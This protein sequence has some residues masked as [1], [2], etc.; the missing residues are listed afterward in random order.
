[1]KNH[2]I[3]SKLRKNEIV[4]L[5]KNK[6]IISYYDTS[7]HGSID[8]SIFGIRH[9]A[10]PIV[11]CYEDLYYDYLPMPVLRKAT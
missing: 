8:E 3:K 10:N 2:W 5:I 7:Y 1:M 9:N 4:N 11:L 6:P